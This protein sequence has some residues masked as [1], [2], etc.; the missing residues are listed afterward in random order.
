MHLR[1]DIC[2][3]PGDTHHCAEHHQQPASE[4]AVHMTLMDG[5]MI[6]SDRPIYATGSYRLA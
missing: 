5:G 3:N 4:H 2:S 1:M 6:D